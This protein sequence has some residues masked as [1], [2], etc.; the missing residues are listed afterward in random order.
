VPTFSLC[1]C[2]L[3]PRLNVLKQISHVTGNL[4]S[5]GTSTSGALKKIN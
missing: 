5:D 3:V 4:S 2:K 1:S